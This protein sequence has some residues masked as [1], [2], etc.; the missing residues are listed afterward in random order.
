LFLG[1]LTINWIFGI[2]VLMLVKYVFLKK[3]TN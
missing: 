3:L 2:S 1:L